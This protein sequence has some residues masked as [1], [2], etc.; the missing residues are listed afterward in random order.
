M[1]LRV[2]HGIIGE[3]TLLTEEIERKTLGW[4]VMTRMA[5]VLKLASPFQ[6]VLYADDSSI[7]QVPMKA[8]QVDT[9]ESEAILCYIVQT[10]QVPTAQQFQDL[11]TAISDKDVMDLSYLLG[12]GVDLNCPI[13]DGGHTSTLVASAILRDH[14]F[15]QYAYQPSDGHCFP[16]HG[17]SLTYLLLQARADPNILP[18][19]PQP[20]TMLELAVE[21]GSSQLVQVLLEAGASV[22]PVK[23]A[24]PPL[25]LAV[26]HRHRTNVQLLLDAQ[27]DPWQE[28]TIASVL[29]HSP[30]WHGHAARTEVFNAVQAAAAQSPEDTVIDL[31]QQCNKA[32]VEGRKRQS[33]LARVTPTVLTERATT[34]M[35]QTVWKFQNIIDKQTRQTN[36]TTF[37][38]RR[39]LEGLYLPGRVRIVLQPPPEPNQA[40]AFLLQV[41]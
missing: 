10:P 19:K 2:R 3:E 23:G 4:D 17:A 35:Q 40:E 16:H 30:Q 12:K 32:T 29:C 25:F 1:R 34:I 13:T 33:S 28:I 8:L 15:D 14:S 37:R 20:T 5:N 24:L 27:A 41:D 6:V 11:M 22:M 36:F 31:L 18:P 9:E 21:L 26:L 39:I 7:I 38:W